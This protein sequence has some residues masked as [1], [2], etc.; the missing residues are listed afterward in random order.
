MM[1]TLITKSFATTRIFCKPVIKVVLIRLTNSR[2]QE[3]GFLKRQL[4]RHLVPLLPPHSLKILP[5]RRSDKNR[6]ASSKNNSISSHSHSLNNT[7]KPYVRCCAFLLCLTSVSLRHVHFYKVIP[8][9]LQLLIMLKNLN[10]Q[11][12]RT[13]FR[14]CNNNNNNNNNNK[15]RQIDPQLH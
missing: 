9:L 11:H 7:N 2:Q 15:K 10:R 3:S 14:L 12:I 5:N 1:E 8:C 6:S 13:I 4:L